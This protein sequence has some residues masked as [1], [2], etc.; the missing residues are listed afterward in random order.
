MAAGFKQ[1]TVNA[2]R[3]PS[4]QTNFPAYVDLSRLGITTLAE[5]QS[6]R[7]YADIA[8]TTEWARQIVSVSVMYVKVPSLTSTVSIYID[9]DGVRADYAVTDTYGRN[10]V[11][12]DYRAVY[13]L[14]DENDSTAN[15]YHLSQTT[16]GGVT[17]GTGPTGHAA[18]SPDA[19]PSN[20]ALRR[21]SFAMMTDAEYGGS[22][23]STM[24]LR[25]NA[26][27]FTW[28]YMLMLRGSGTRYQLWCQATDAVIN[29]LGGG[30]TGPSMSAL[31]VN[32]WYKLDIVAD[33][34]N[35]SIYR[36]GAFVTSASG[37]KVVSSA[38]QD[39]YGILGYVENTVVDSGPLSMGE[40]RV[41]TGTSQ[42][43][44]DWIT[45]EYNNQS[46]ESDFWGTWT[47]AGALN[48]SPLLAMS[49]NA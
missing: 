18:T 33:G 27:G 8:K 42:S 40:H 24:W 29:F 45:T 44:A 41:I 25:R 22:W 48:P 28:W 6:V 16:A 34:T 2:S 30:A 47:N 37:Y 4:T 1:A 19:Y 11:W 20:K 36:D 14:N 23:R 3:V 38:Y 49:I 13:H 12:S 39:C 15:A 46:N 9:Y 5:A 35:L 21:A 31:T 26:S 17:F 43:S 32:Q 10:A 7:V